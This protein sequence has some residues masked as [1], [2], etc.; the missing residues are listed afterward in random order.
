MQLFRTIEHSAQFRIEKKKK[1][2]KQN[3]TKKNVIKRC[4]KRG[5]QT[6]WST[7]THALDSVHNQTISWAFP[8]MTKYFLLIEITSFLPDRAIFMF[9][10]KHTNQDVLLF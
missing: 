1:F 4:N 9:D 5:K 7:H 3:N 2:G 10:L 8:I 6:D